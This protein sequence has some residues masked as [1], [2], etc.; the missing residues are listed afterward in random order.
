MI[1][2]KTPFRI[3]FLGGGTD[4]KDY[5]ETNGGLVIS[6]TIDKFAYVILK[7]LPPFFNYT[8]KISYSIIET[9]S[10]INE[11]RH[12]MIRE[13]LREFERKNIHLAYDS[14]L[15]AK[16]GLGSSSSFAVGLFNA[17]FT[18]EGRV[19]TKKELSDNAIRI[20]RD[21]LKE[22]GGHQD[23]IAVSYGGLNKIEFSKNG[24]CV[25][26]IEITEDRKK[27][28]NKNLMLFFTGFDRYAFEI[29]NDKIKKMH[30]NAS[31]YDEMKQ[32]AY[33]GIKILESDVSLV[34]FGKLLHNSWLTK[35]K[36]S[37]MVSNHDIDKIY[38][39]ALA[40]GAIGGK[41]LGA[42]GGGFLLIYAEYQVQNDIKI[43][44]KDLLYVPFKF[45]DEGSSILYNF[46]KSIIQE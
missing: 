43:A 6:A 2:T 28:L 45:E 13:V 42:G 40:A 27:E 39:R 17:L 8:Y 21:I 5:Y 9:V 31:L 23:Q 38:H 29:E 19:I 15:P 16:T 30:Q 46:N 36:L 11:I 20:E 44:L 14:D 34:E 10:K 12:P 41:L 33:E 18:L 24:Y 1:I 4:F 26:P 32:H 7:E 37:G 22:A 25:F 3:S 35:K